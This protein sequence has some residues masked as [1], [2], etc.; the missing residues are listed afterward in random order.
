MNEKNEGDRSVE[1]GENWLMTPVMHLTLLMDKWRVC[2]LCSLLLLLHSH[3]QQQQGV[4]WEEEE[5]VKSYFETVTKSRPVVVVQ[6]GDL[7]LLCFFFL[8]L[9]T[10]FLL[11]WNQVFSSLFFLSTCSSVAW[12]VM[13]PNT[14][15]SLS[16]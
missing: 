11:S 15:D 3:Q 2:V 6:E 1:K 16:L 8:T 9:P 14:S 5:E 7:Y 13:K 12:P 10:G 4:N